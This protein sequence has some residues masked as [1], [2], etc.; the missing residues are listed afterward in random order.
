MRN[1]KNFCT[2]MLICL[3][4]MTEH[5]VRN[6]KGSN[7]FFIFF[8]F[9]GV[10]KVD[11]NLQKVDIDQCSSD[12]WFSGTHKCHLNNSEVRT[13]KQNSLK[14]EAHKRFTIIKLYVFICVGELTRRILIRKKNHQIS[15][16]PNEL[17][18]EKIKFV[19][20]SYSFWDSLE[21]WPKLRLYMKFN[22]V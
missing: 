18:L 12:G 9:R 22:F 6:D 20:N 16:L 7:Y 11:I 15:V 8:N 10:M 14:S 2:F 13:W 3:I 17:K 4:S 1:L 5:R 21:R 19:Q